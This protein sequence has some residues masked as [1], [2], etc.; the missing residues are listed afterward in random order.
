MKRYLVILMA[1]LVASA[2]II[3]GC[4]TSTTTTAPAKTTT[5]V[6]TTTPPATTP[7]V[8]KKIKFSYTMPKGASTGAGFE[9]FATEFPKRTNGRYIV[10]TYPSETLTKISVALDAIKAGT[11]EI[12]GTSTGTFPKAFPLTLVVSIPT[13][14]FPG[15]VMSSYVE[16]SGAIWDLLQ[17]STGSAERIQG[18][19]IT[20]DLCPGPLQPGFQK[21]GNSLC[22]RL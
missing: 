15:G 20:L 22:G 19:Q 3:T 14:S 16:G 8:A 12:I 4:N 17:C 1:I 18:L 11:A 5:A 13:L 9:W 10:E 2:L 21:E 6:V 7:V